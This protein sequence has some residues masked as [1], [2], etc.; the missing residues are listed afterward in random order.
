[1]LNPLS[2]PGRNLQKCLRLRTVWIAV[3][4]RIR[5]VDAP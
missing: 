5:F 1:M 4:Q 2:Q 3:H